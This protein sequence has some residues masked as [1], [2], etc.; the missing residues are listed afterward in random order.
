METFINGEWGTVCNSGWDLVDAQVVCM[1][2]GQSRAIHVTDIR[3]FGPGGGHVWLSGID[4]QGNETRLVN[5]PRGDDTC[6]DHSRDIGV[7]CESEYL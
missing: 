4:C 3:S 7:V 6:N 2:L 1:E 5:C